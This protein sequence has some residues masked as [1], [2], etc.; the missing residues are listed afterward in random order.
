[1]TPNI[2]S[3][4]LVVFGTRIPVKTILAYKHAGEKVEDI[5]KDYGL[6][7]QITQK[8]LAHIDVHQKVA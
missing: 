6:D 8:A 2:Q 1:M 3:G 5:A 7:P 4:R